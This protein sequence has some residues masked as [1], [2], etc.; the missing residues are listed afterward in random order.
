MALVSWVLEMHRKLDVK[1]VLHYCAITGEFTWIAN[2]RGGVKSG[3]VAGYIH[4]SGYRII[5]ISGVRYRAHRLAWFYIT[6]SIP[7]NQI[8]HINQNRSDNRFINLRA[9]TP[10]INA[11]NCKKRIDNKSGFT[12]AYFGNQCK[13]WIAEIKVNGKKVHLGSFSSMCL[14]VKAR[15]NAN[16][17]YDFHKNH[18]GVHAS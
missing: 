9:A 3:D 11:K 12:G 5:V 17:I 8:D 6:G 7:E 14:A 4:S 18:G 2:I 15:K 10:A 16:I 13:K 1:K